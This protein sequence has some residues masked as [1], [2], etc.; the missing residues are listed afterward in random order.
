MSG[1]GTNGSSW[2][3]PIISCLASGLLEGYRAPTWRYTIDV[4]LAI[5]VRGPHSLMSGLAGLAETVA[6]CA[7]AISRLSLVTSQ[8]SHCRELRCCCLGKRCL[9]MLRP[10]PCLLCFTDQA[11]ASVCMV[12]SWPFPAQPVSSDIVGCAPPPP[13][14][15]GSL[16]STHSGAPRPE[17]V[18]VRLIGC[19]ALATPSGNAHG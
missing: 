15:G 7:R 17:I 16:C 12:A 14:S 18:D 3:R 9:H 5:L 8:H 4:H 2:A 13:P 19:C 11:L 1:N 6:I 10:Q